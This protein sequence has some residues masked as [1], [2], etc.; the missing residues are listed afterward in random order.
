MRTDTVERKQEDQLADLA[1]EDLQ[2]A[3]DVWR[4]KNMMQHR[5][6]TAQELAEYMDVSRSWVNL[7]LNGLAL[8]KIRPDTRRRRIERLEDAVTGIT[9]SRGGVPL[10]CCSPAAQAH[11]AVEVLQYTAQVEV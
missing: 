10:A 11:M 9:D 4:L 8:Q 1:V 3:L 7:A 6:I 2:T 5:N